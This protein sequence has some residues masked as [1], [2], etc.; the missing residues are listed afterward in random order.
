MEMEPVTV[1]N[2]ANTT[3]HQI[4]FIPLA[5]DNTKAISASDVEMKIVKLKFY[6]IK[7]KQTKEGF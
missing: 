7:L 6:N 3:A 2:D 5:V 1:P 4:L